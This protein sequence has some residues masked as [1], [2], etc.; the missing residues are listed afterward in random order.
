MGLALAASAGCTAAPAALPAGVS[1]SIYQ[2]R[3]DY[4]PRALQ[5]TVINGSDAPLTVTRAT[6]VSPRFDG[7][8]A[9][10]RPTTVAAGARVNLRVLLGDPVCDG[11]LGGTVELAFTTADG[12]S[13]TAVLDPVDE[14]ST[15]GKVTAEDCLS[16]GTAA[17]ATITMGTGIRTEQRGDRL[18]GLIDVTATPTGAEG[19]ASIT[20]VTR[21]ILLR[22]E[23]DGA[24]QWALDWTVDAA[25][26][27]LTTALPFEPS[28]CNPHIV[29]EDKLG[30]FFPFLVTLADG[31]S[32]TVFYGVTDEVRG[33]VYAYI[34]EYCGW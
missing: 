16:E 27:T 15:L 23:E 29:A 1:T 22:P 10:T 14:F 13:G 6:Y 24:T 2:Q 32:G 28:N 31:T 12:R 7:T 8:T 9:W 11:E 3:P 30:T 17:V 21:T 34:A 5:V 19:T 20:G 18:I 4:G 33:Q 26:G 25:S